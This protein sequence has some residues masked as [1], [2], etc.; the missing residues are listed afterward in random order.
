MKKDSKICAVSDSAEVGSLSANAL[1]RCSRCGAT[2]SD[3]SALCDPVQV[4]GE[5]QIGG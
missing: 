2:S 5:G 4:S 3:P 1:A